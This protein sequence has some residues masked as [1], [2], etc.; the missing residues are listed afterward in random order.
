MKLQS[1]IKKID[2]KEIATCILLIVVGYMTAQLFMRKYNRFS[3]GGQNSCYF[4]NDMSCKLGTF[5]Q[6]SGGGAPNPDPCNKAKDCNKSW[7]QSKSDG[8]HGKTP[9]GVGCKFV[10][11]K[12]VTP[13]TGFH[14]IS[15][16]P[17]KSCNDSA[18]SPPPPPTNSPPSPTVSCSSTGTWTY[19]A[20]KC[21]INGSTVSNQSYNKDCKGLTNCKLTTWG[22][23]PIWLSIIISI[24]II[25]GISIYILQ[26]EKN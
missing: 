20:D 18:N 12:C 9:I 10:N 11:N 1:Y 6:K 3:V 8:G 13:G 22:K 5:Q 19:Y 17:T 21:L 14:S 24:L 16:C 25:I 15:G 2:T 4:G 26:S 7:W 23:P